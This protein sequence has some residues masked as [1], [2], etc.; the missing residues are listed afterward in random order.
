MGDMFRLLAASAALLLAAVNANAALIINGS[1]EDPAINSS[2]ALLDPSSVPGW[3]S[4]QQMEIRST[5]TLAPSYE[6]NQHLELNSAGSAPWSIWQVMTTQ[7][8]TWYEL[9]FAAARRSGYGSYN[10]FAVDI[11]D[12]STPSTN[13]LNETVVLND[14]EWNLFTFKF[15][16]V[17]SSTKLIFTSLYPNS[18]GGNFLDTVSVVN[19][20]NDA[21]T[22]PAPS[23]IALMSLAIL[24]LGAR[25]LYK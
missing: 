15:K 20:L 9:T 17:G 8:D 23:S 1:F 2:W 13:L 10:S 25:R 18:T 24:G 3:E 22:I 4:N 6:G 11:F 19:Y 16:A 5:F 12:N 7:T 14:T 21:D